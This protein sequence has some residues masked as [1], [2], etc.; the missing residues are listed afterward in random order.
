M[1]VVEQNLL[2]KFHLSW[3]YATKNEIKDERAKADHRKL[4]KFIEENPTWTELQVVEATFGKQK[5]GH[6]T[7]FGG[8][9]RPKDLKGSPFT[10]KADL[11]AKLK[12]TEAQNSVLQD[13]VTSLHTTVTEIMEEVR[14]LRE[15]VGTT[16]Q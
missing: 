3:T 4:Q 13:S 2:G 10:S 11:A 5:K 14:S 9:V 16:R 7:G 8:G 12:Q 1:A 6:V 15:M